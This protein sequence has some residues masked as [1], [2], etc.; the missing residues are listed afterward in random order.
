MLC[1]G[2]VNCIFCKIIIIKKVSLF[3]SDF[4]RKHK[5]NCFCIQ[6]VVSG[7]RQPVGAVHCGDASHRLFILEKEGYVKIFTPE[8]DIIKEPFLDIHK[9][10]QS[11]IKVGILFYF[12]LICL[13]FNL[14]I[15]YPPCM[16]F[17]FKIKIMASNSSFFQENI[18]I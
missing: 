7:L 5:H 15:C 9:L 3:F 17:S 10:V 16:C 12:S 6:E 4:F 18:L 2:S 14:I 1:E 8:G 11:G 13:Y